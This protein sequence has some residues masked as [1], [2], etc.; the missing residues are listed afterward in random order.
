[1]GGIATG[2]VCVC[3]SWTKELLRV[4]AKQAGLLLCGWIFFGDF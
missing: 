4:N 3:V 1:L 2:Q